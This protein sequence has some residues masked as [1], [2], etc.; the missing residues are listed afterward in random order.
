MIFPSKKIRPPL[1]HMINK[2]QHWS[3][4]APSILWNEKHGNYEGF[5]SIGKIH[6]RALWNKGFQSFLMGGIAPA[7]ISKEKKSFIIL[8]EVFI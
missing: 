8:Y 2:H 1:E 5:Q 4:L 7:V 6:T 3:A